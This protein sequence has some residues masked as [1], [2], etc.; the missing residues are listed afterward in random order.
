MGRVPAA[1]FDSAEIFEKEIGGEGSMTDKIVKKIYYKIEFE[2]ASP[3]T[4]GTGEN[5][6][7]DK[8]IARDSK[9]IPYIP[10]SALAGINRSFFEDGDIKNNYFGMI[11]MDKKAIESRIIFYD[12]KMCSDTYVVS[13]RDS[14]ALDSYK[15]AIDGA[16]FDMEILE[17]G[18]KFVTYIE[19]NYLNEGD[20]AIGDE[21]VKHWLQ[22]EV[23]IGAKTMRGY[24]AV[25]NVSVKKKVFCFEK[26]TDVNDWLAF[27]MY[28]ES[29]WENV[30]PEIQPN[31]EQEYAIR[32]ELK[33]VGGISIRKYT[34]KAA[35]NDKNPI[36]DYEQ[37]CVHNKDISLPVI[38]G[39]S[40]AGAFRHR[41]LQLIPD[42]DQKACFGLVNLEE[43]VKSNIRFSE[44][45]IINATEKI[46][47]RNAINRFTGGTVDG[48]LFTEK[49]YYGGETT[50]V[51]SFVKNPTADVKA[52]LAAAVADLHNGFLAVGGLTAIGR[53]CFVI[54][55]INGVETE[56]SD[57]YQMVLEFMKKWEEK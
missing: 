24:G 17:P 4:I 42:L 14:V 21:L 52:A 16:K 40:W 33:Q 15:T 9:G 56:N 36:P 35:E 19:Q 31:E 7:T 45:Q 47:S 43:K 55:S 57:I 25:Q 39:T 10:G 34:T 27:E 26:E 1:D 50:L 49:T 54:K 41:M 44:T 18:V 32:L 3:M 53:G 20:R 30:T 2:L 22:E 46:H 6:F 51:I 38:P 23:Y 48:A 37:L 8:D 13:K 28:E 11:S 12:A 29:A 5:Q